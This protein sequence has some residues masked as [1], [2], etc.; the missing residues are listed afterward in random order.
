MVARKNAQLTPLRVE[1]FLGGNLGLTLRC[2][3][4]LIINLGMDQCFF[5]VGSE[6][7]NCNKLYL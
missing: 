3:Q 5:N 2:V 1:E 7:T 4:K 6:S